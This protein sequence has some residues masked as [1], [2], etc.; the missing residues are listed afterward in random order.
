M[1]AAYAPVIR[2]ASCGVS[3]DEQKPGRPKASRSYERMRSAC[4]IYPDGS[5]RKDNRLQIQKV[6]T[7]GQMEG[8]SQLVELPIGDLVQNREC[9]IL[10]IKLG[11]LFHGFN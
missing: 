2:S 10:H 8:V 3:G 1:P 9:G 7:V 6:L 11:A 5:F 4:V